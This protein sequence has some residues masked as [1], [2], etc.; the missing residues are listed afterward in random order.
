[1]TRAAERLLG[2][3]TPR[4]RRTVIG[5]VVGGFIEWYDFVI[6][7]L[8]APVLAD[9]FFPEGS[10]TA[11][12]LGIFAIYAVAFLM[13]PLG[14]LYFGALGDRIGRK[15]VLSATVLLI[16][17]ATLVIG[18]LPTYGQIGISAAALLLVA[19]LVQGFSA[20]GE[21]AGG[22]SFVIE[23]APAHR[24]GAWM[25][26]FVASAFAP[27]AVGALLIV[28]LQATMGA[29]GYQAWGWRIP[30]ILGGVVAVFGLWIRRKLDDP[31]EYT[32]SRAQD[33]QV[34]SPLRKAASQHLRSIVIVV[35][36]IAV[37]AVGA[38]MLNSYMLTFIATETGMASTS[39]LLALSLSI[40]LITLAL[41]FAGLLT[42]KVGRKPMLVAGGVW[43]L[44]L[45]VPAFLL[46]LQ[47]TFLAAAAGTLIL[48]IGVTVYSAGGYV[49]LFELFPTQVRA[50]GV[51]MAYNIGFTI[52]GGTTP[53]I[54]TALTDNFGS[55]APAYY[56]VVI[57]A[58]GLL[59]VRKTPETLGS[60]IRHDI[61]DGP[62]PAREVP[63]VPYAPERS[64]LDRTQKRT[65]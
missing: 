6:Y 58:I 44:V 48:A 60:N 13:R 57:C 50:S 11:A 39:I 37:Q 7:G 15:H 54:S 14:G 65:H 17:A 38:Y 2:E 62:M 4:T 16:G 42:D 61:F 31:E 55:L 1:M 29:D 10:P 51:A 47:G 22:G 35:F 52:F 5:G 28:G 45:S 46:V 8:S 34:K 63:E 30:F 59:V 19:R 33:G 3:Y 40:G 64:S 12:L 9:L 24:R 49:T 53:L 21:S 36:L 23:S 43:L 20:G 32:E 26:F 27:G 25:G 41:P 56:M 18:L